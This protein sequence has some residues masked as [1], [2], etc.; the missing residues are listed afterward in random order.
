MSTFGRNRNIER[1]KYQLYISVSILLLDESWSTSKDLYFAHPYIVITK[2][3]P[4]SAIP[5]RTMRIW[6]KIILQLFTWMYGYLNNLIIELWSLNCSKNFKETKNYAI[7]QK[8]LLIVSNENIILSQPQ[9]KHY[10]GILSLTPQKT[11]SPQQTFLFYSD[12][13]N[14]LFYVFTSLICPAS[15][16]K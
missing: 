10:K 4:N 5:T 7:M 14:F 2:P 12:R 11:F 8:N 6:S 1:T 13:R 3:K 16:R 15:L 9:T